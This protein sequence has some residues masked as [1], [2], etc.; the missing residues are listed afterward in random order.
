MFYQ[1]A[2]GFY[3]IPLYFLHVNSLRSLTNTFI[4]DNPYLDNVYILI[5]MVTGK[6]QYNHT[7]ILIAMVTGKPQYNHTYILCGLLLCFQFSI[8]NHIIVLLI[9]LQIFPPSCFTSTQKIFDCHGNLYQLFLSF[10]GVLVRFL[11][12]TLQT[13]TVSVCALGAGIKKQYTY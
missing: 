5:A 6:P 12:Q 2:P 3:M 7:Y 10:S 8:Y 13:R 4:V 1:T 9:Y 11:W